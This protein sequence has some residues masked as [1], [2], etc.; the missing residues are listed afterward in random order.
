MID[1]V[2]PIYYQRLFLQK[3]KV[4]WASTRFM[5]GFGAIVIVFYAVLFTALSPFV[6]G[7]FYKYD[8]YLVVLASLLIPSGALEYYTLQKIFA[9]YGEKLLLVYSALSVFISYTMYFFV[10]PE[11]G[12]RGILYMLVLRQFLQSILFLNVKWSLKK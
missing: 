3:K 6:F 4:N 9:L 10:L 1:A 8:F 2:Y 7:V 12:I 5:L 11:G